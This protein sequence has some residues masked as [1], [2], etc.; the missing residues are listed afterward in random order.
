MAIEDRLATRP[1]HEWVE[2][3]SAAG[4]PCAPVN[5]VEQA[6]GDPQVVAREGIWE[7][8]HPALGAVRQVAS[9]LRMSDAELP[10]ER[11]PLRGEHTES[12]L[13]E[14]CGYDD[15]AIARLQGEKE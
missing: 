12:V 4:V 6:L 15:E 2:V 5:S 9:P 14:L 1:V 7:Y 10:N 8:A 11:A 3:L 13:R